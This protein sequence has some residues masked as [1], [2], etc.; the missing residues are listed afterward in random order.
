MNDLIGDGDVV[1]LT[2]FVHDARAA[3]EDLSLTGRSAGTDMTGGVLTDSISV[4]FTKYMN[5]ITHIGSDFAST[6]PGV[7]YRDFEKTTLAKNGMIFAPYPASR[8]LCAMGGI[9]SNN[10][11]PEKFKCIERT[12]WKLRTQN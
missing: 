10:G 6:E 4:V 3:G 12:I 9:V 7:Y 5:H 11:R 1:A 2:K 8:E